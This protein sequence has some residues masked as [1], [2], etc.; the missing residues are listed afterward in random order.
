LIDSKTKT[1][2]KDQDG[3]KKYYTW[4]F[5]PEREEG[6]PNP[7]ATAQAILALRALK[8]DGIDKIIASSV[9]YIKD[10][11]DEIDDSVTGTI[12]IET[13][14]RLM[15]TLT[16]EI[17]FSHPGIQQ[18][19]RVLLIETSSTDNIVVSLLN[20]NLEKS[21]DFLEHLHKFKECNGS[22]NEDIREEV[23]TDTREIYPTLL[24]FLYYLRPPTLK[25]LLLDYTEFKSE[26]ESFV[27]KAQSVIVVG[28][29]DEV[30]GS[31]MPPKV[32]IFSQ[33]TLE[34]FLQCRY[35]NWKRYTLDWKFENI[36]CVIVDKKEGL[37]SC[38]PFKETGQYNIINHMEE[39]EVSNLINQLEE[40]VGVKIGSPE[41][42]IK[43]IISEKFPKQSGIMDLKDLEN[44]QLEG[45]LEYFKLVPEQTEETL[46]PA[47]VLNNRKAVENEF[48]RRGIFSRV[49]VNSSL[50]GLLKK[51]VDTDFTPFLV[52]DESSAYLLLNTK[53][54]KE[55]EKVIN[56]CSKCLR[57]SEKL[58]IA[59]D[60]HSEVKKFLEDKIKKGV[61]S[62]RISK[63]GK[64]EIGEVD[65]ETKFNELKQPDNLLHFTKNE[66][67][68]IVCAAQG[69]DY[70]VITNSWEVATMCKVNNI[71]TFSIM[72]F[73]EEEGK[74]KNIYRIFR[75]PVDE[76]RQEEAT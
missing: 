75:V 53:D 34:P 64:D 59:P 52:L 16:P 50:K 41:E 56:C 44:N 65:Y 14:I 30:Y 1:Y 9:N 17:P 57:K 33:P 36:N 55:E 2:Q 46:A 69:E 40:I 25:G 39:D 3:T 42:E 4:S 71:K 32:T 29:V 54:T 45:I 22:E 19:L 11:K 67:I 70:G 21:N 10:K 20:K 51:S 8:V 73:L 12:D 68:A 61:R 66:K 58:F 38:N 31:M 76:F 23:T 27:S 7:T 62:E 37:I 43:E 6:K 28:E 49:F 18:C 74:N 35:P 72:K 13:K 48:S 63:I 5:Q 47:L 24:S 60:V 15:G 26:F